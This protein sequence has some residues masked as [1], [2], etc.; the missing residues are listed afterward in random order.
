MPN[1]ASLSPRPVRPGEGRGA[2]PGPSCR[3]VVNMLGCPTMLVSLKSRRAA[4]SSSFPG[5]VANSQSPCVLHDRST[6]PAATRCHQHQHLGM[7]RKQRCLPSEA[8]AASPVPAVRS[9]LVFHGVRAIALTALGEP[10]PTA[11]ESPDNG[12]C[13]GSRLVSEQ[14]PV[15]VIAPRVHA[16]SAHTAR[17]TSH[18]EH[19]ILHLSG[20]LGVP[21]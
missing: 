14:Q 12:S 2:R 9:R 6:T 19:D 10:A 18:A 17:G 5:D 13:D 21:L 4:S 11:S 20:A 7:R 8:G 1:L 3:E 15:H 16:F